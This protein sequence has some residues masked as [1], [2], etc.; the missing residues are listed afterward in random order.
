M[1][2]N[3]KC[4][5]HV[6]MAGVVSTILLSTTIASAAYVYHRVTSTRKRI[7]KALLNAGIYRQELLAAV[8]VALAAGVN[9]K[10]AIEEE[11]K[12]SSKGNVDFVTETD[13]GNEKLIINALHSQF[14]SYSFI[15]EVIYN[16]LNRKKYL[17]NWVID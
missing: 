5:F 14:P 2:L 15:G 11:K 1:K 12:I 8:E 3:T 4:P 17:I 6:F 7:P 10:T 16:I 13:K 9:I